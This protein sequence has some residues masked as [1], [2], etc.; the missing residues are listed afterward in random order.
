MIMAM[1]M[2]IPT[3][4][5][6]PTA[7]IDTSQVMFRLM[8]WLSPAFP[9]GAFSYSHGLEWAAEAGLVFDKTTLESW[10]TAGLRHEFGPLN[11]SILRAAWEATMARDA[12][13]FAEALADARA[14]VPTAE[15]ELETMA[16]GGAFFS[17]LSKITRG[18]ECFDW[19][20]KH[21]AFEPG[22][23]PYP[24][25]VGCLAASADAPLPLALTAYFQS[26]VGN[27]VSSGLRLISLGQTAGQDIVASLEGA[28]MAVTQDVLTRAPCDV[29]VAAPMIEWSSMC[30]ETQYTRLFRS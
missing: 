8:T 2:I 11:G 27:L 1:T 5:R 15:F 18:S 25:V 14:L 17:T 23:V 20:Q 30:H 16:Q 7:M 29:G 12:N 9:V 4:I 10:I 26:V 22:P 19:V 3:P 13:G 24:F 6:I 28:V 21:I